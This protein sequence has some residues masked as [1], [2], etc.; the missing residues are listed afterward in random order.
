MV[1]AVKIDRP[2]T[3]FIR[4]SIDVGESGYFSTSHDVSGSTYVTV[5][6]NEATPFVVTVKFEFPEVDKYDISLKRITADST[7]GQLLN[8]TSWTI[9]RSFEN[10]TVLDLDVDHS[11]FELSLRATEQV[12]G[13]VENLN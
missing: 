7:S 12:N 9:L 11:I 5:T 1:V 4:T 2:F 8:G 10:D 3:N 13:I 6:N